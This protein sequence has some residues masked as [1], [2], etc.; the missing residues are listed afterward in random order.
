[1]TKKEKRI[2]NINLHFSKA[3]LN[4]NF[5]L[6]NRILKN[7]PRDYVIESLESN[8]N[9][10]II[11]FILVVLSSAKHGHNLFDSLNFSTQTKVLKN[12]NDSELI[13]IL[14]LLFPDEVHELMQS[15]PK[16]YKKIL[17]LINS[18]TR[19]AIKKLK[20]Y[21][22]DEIASIMNPEFII[23]RQSWSIKMCLKII[24]QE[25]QNFEKT[26]EIFILDRQGI[27]K[28]KV[29][30][31]DL[32][33]SQDLNAKITSISDSSYISVKS[34]SDIDNVIQIFEKYSIETL[35]VCNNNGKLIGIIKDVDIIEAIQE[36]TTE[37]IYKMYGMSELKYPYINSSIW[38][39][40]KSRLLWLIILMISATLTSL[41]IDRF[42]IY[43]GNLIGA[44][45]STALLVPLIPVLTG[46]SGNAGS[47]SSAAIIRAISIGEITK[48]DYW[49]VIQKEILIG[50]SIGLILAVINIIRLLI[51]NAAINGEAIP[52]LPDADW[53]KRF[54]YRM[55]TGCAVS[56][57][58]W[59]SIIFSKT[60]GATLPILAVKMK[61]DPT[62]M[63]APILSTILDVSTTTLLFGIGI[64]VISAI[65]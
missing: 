18:E 52:T 15:H 4:K 57:A 44:G 16:Y 29:S 49:K 47:Q 37:D 63:S 56:L 59:I 19:K 1:M 22:E 65:N 28:G 7:N 45:L 9:I 42:Q 55:I 26:N 33:F 23:L 35:P 58:L 40:L 54:E 32:L 50:V 41:I 25:R 8:K 6:V 51:Y 11:I 31:Q 43:A 17:L 53:L 5:K 2:N 10:K 36:E 30:I 62:V 46:T 27:L 12:G 24:R 60:L 20:N 34:K 39:I 48:K 21:E 61:I 3:Y 38:S 64:G 13:A 14:K